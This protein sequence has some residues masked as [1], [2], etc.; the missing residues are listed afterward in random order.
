MYRS[1]SVHAKYLRFAATEA[2]VENPPMA[3]DG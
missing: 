2:G 1:N 3:L